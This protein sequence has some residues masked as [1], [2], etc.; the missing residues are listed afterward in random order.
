M[1]GQGTQGT[2]DHDISATEPALHRDKGA[3]ITKPEY[4]ETVGPVGPVATESV[5]HVVD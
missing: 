4:V 2:T 3:G 1:S 5:G